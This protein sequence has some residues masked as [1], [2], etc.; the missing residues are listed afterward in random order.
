MLPTREHLIGLV[1]LIIAGDESEDQVNEWIGVLEQNVPDPNV[2][3]LIYYPNEPMTP[4]EIVDKALAYNAQ[5]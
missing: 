3:D 1:R 4:E 2:S 5:L